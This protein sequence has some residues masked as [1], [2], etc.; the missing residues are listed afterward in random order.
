MVAT[1]LIWK[2]W[3]DAEPQPIVWGAMLSAAMAASRRPGV[4]L[5]GPGWRLFVARNRESDGPAV[6]IDRQ[7]RYVC[8]DAPTSDESQGDIDEQRWIET[9]PFTFFRIDPLREELTIGRDLMGERTLVY[10][11]IAQGVLVA[12]AESIL[13]AHP[14]IGSDL[15]E[16]F[17]AA[18]LISAPPE[19]DA[20]AFS[21]IRSLKSGELKRWTCSDDSSIRATLQADDSV[22]CRDHSALVRDFAEL[23]HAAVVKRCKGARRIGVSLS[24]GIDSALVAVEAVKARDS[25]KAKPVAVTYGFDRWPEVD[26]RGMG[27]RLADFLDLDWFGIAADELHPMRSSLRRPICPD[28]PMATPFREIKEAVY[29]RFETEGVDVW[30]TGNFGDHLYAVPSDWMLDALNRRRYVRAAL[31]CLDMFRARGLWGLWRDRGFRR[32]MRSILGLSAATWPEVDLLCAP[33]GERLRDRLELELASYKRFPRPLQA[34][35]VLDANACMDACGENWFAARHGMELR[36]PYRDAKLTRFCL[37]APASLS[38]KAAQWK[39]QA[40]EAYVNRLPDEIRCRAKGSDLTEF[41]DSAMKAEKSRLD[42]LRAQG[43]DVAGHLL[44][45]RPRAPDEGTLWALNWS[46]ISLGAWLEAR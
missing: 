31:L 13:S 45:K 43:L 14:E 24:A 18:F 25:S 10:A 3:R 5:S 19:H 26:E 2:S 40:R 27:S 9:A 1:I 21:R 32:G 6:E 11:R 34:M 44:R 33:L 20:T 37:S 4:T 17:L 15:N 42:L 38:Y 29:Q 22:A 16:E 23:V 46:L 28:T 7:G 36:S 12:T 8:I 35:S 41:T 39:A 30:L